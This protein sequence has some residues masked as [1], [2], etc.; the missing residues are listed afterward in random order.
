MQENPNSKDRDIIC[1][2]IITNL[3][4]LDFELN[5]EELSFI[6]VKLIKLL[7]N[8]EKTVRTFTNLY[9]LYIRIEVI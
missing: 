3:F 9:R 5:I 2:E 6:T 7:N 4:V 8:G 1:K